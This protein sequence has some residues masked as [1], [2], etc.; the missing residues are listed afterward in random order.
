MGAQLNDIAP[1]LIPNYAGRSPTAAT[2]N[3]AVTELGCV[4]RGTQSPAANIRRLADSRR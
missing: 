1:L 4:T 2:R 3:C